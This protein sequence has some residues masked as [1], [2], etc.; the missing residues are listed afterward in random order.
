M[1]QLVEKLPACVLTNDLYNDE[2]SKIFVEKLLNPILNEA[3]KLE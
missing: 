2:I 1:L 3:Y